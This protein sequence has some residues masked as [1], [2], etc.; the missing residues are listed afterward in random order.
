[1]FLA[2]PALAFPPPSD[3]LLK[4]PGAEAGASGHGQ[5]VGVPSWNLTGSFTVDNYG[6][7]DRPSTAVSQTIYGDKNYFFG[8]PGPQS[9]ST[10]TQMV[11]VSAYADEIDK[12]ALLSN[13]GGDLGSYGSQGDRMDLR[14]EFLGADGHALGTRTITGPAHR[15]TTGFILFIYIDPVPVG[16]RSVRMT[17][18]STR[19]DGNNNDGYAD[20]VELFLRENT[21]TGTAGM[22]GKMVRSFAA[23][24]LFSLK[25]SAAAA[26]VS[27]L[28][29]KIAIGILGLE[30]SD[31]ARILAA[32][33]FAA[34]LKVL[35][36]SPPGGVRVSLLNALP[37]TLALRY[38]NALG[39]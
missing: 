8:G 19:T 35:K 28:D 31:G 24:T 29:P 9:V 30:P 37:S 2:A 36:N 38:R 20:N 13:F 39:R 1:M 3:N 26:A 12:G 5:L 22:L 25:T 15:T 32:M 34:G 17:L 16:T 33:P 27:L 14:G 18:T 4:N 21:P 7:V 6:D 23:K 11:D 10:A